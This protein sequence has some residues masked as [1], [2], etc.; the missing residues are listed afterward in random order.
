MLG[1]ESRQSF[2]DNHDIVF[3]VMNVKG[4]AQENNV[5]IRWSCNHSCELPWY[6]LEVPTIGISLNYTNHL[7]DV[8]QLHTFVNAYGSNQENIRAAIDK[9]CGNSEFSGTAND[10]VFCGRWDTRL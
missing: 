8:P 6:N 3:L 5:R 4:Y 9:I 2:I 1:H 10:S 7:I